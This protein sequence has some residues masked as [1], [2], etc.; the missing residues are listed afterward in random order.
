M[1]KFESRTNIL[2]MSIKLQM[3]SSQYTIDENIWKINNDRCLFLL[4]VD[5][6][7]IN[8]WCSDKDHAI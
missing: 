8:C 3:L 7:S 5:V 4:S 2:F 6:L 1:F